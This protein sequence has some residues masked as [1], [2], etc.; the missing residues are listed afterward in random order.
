MESDEAYIRLRKEYERLL[1]EKDQEIWK[2]KTKLDDFRRQSA[3][4]RENRFQVYENIEK[5]KRKK[6]DKHWKPTGGYEIMLREAIH[7]YD[8]WKINIR[9]SS[10]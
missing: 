2:L 7:S 6:L 5:R 10:I 3:R 9:N 4:N 1:E 8:Q